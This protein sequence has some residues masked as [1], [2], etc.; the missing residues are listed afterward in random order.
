MTAFVRA[1]NIMK[2]DIRFP[3]A[4]RNPKYTDPY[5]TL[6]AWG[7]KNPISYYMDED[8]FPID[9]P[10]DFND[11]IKD[12]IQYSG[13]EGAFRS[14]YKAGI[15]NLMFDT[16]RGGVVEALNDAGIHDE[17]EVEVALDQWIRAKDAGLLDRLD[18]F[19]D[20]STGPFLKPV[21]RMKRLTDDLT[22]EGGWDSWNPMWYRPPGLKNS[23]GEEWQNDD[24]DETRRYFQEGG[25]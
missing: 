2:S 8:T 5:A 11:D 23:K 13:G 19:T 22:G 14:P 12:G 10:T 17:R 3:S 16:E 15:E 1:W 18:N 6:S 9:P 25:E 4:V 21:D 20:V 7:S 24:L